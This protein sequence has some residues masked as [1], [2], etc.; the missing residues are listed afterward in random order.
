MICKSSDQTVQLSSSVGMDQ[1]FYHLLSK[2]SKLFDFT[3]WNHQEVPSDI[4][5]SEFS[6]HPGLKDSLII[7][8]ILHFQG[9]HRQLAS[10]QWI[11]QS[12]SGSLYDDLQLCLVHICSNDRTYFI[13]DSLSVMSSY[14]KNLPFT[15]PV[16]HL[17]SEILQ[18]IFLYLDAKSLV[19]CSL[20]CRHWRD[21]IA[22]SQCIWKF[23]CLSLK[24]SIKHIKKDRN[25]GLSWK[26]RMY[27]G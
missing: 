6:D 1:R 4:F 19:S 25:K 5:I 20:T 23:Q 8:C 9:T 14:D 12:D 11:L 16:E 7:V 27:L 13:S 26:V 21:L 18:H 17:P 10:W 2:I 15:Y 3:N 22:E 24:D